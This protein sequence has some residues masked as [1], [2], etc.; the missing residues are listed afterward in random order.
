MKTFITCI[1]ISVL[2][3]PLFAQS[4][5]HDALKL[6]EY[7]KSSNFQATVAQFDPAK[8]N[9]ILDNAIPILVNY[10]PD[11]ADI[12]NEADL[13]D[14]YDGNPFI[15]PDNGFSKILLPNVFQSPS[16]AGLIKAEALP[17]ASSGISITNVA[18][19]L[20][21]F[22][23]KRTREELTIT[24]FQK[25]KDKIN[26]NPYFKE[27][28]PQTADLLGLIDNE[29]YQFNAYMESLR[30]HFVKDMKSLPINL[31]SMLRDNQILGDAEQI[32]ADDMLSIAQM[33]IDNQPPEE[34]IKFIGSESE[35]LNKDRISVLKGSV[36]RKYEDAAAGF[37]LAN[38][39]SESLRSSVQG[40]IWVKPDEL[41]ALIQDKLTLYL[42]LGL[43]W[44][45]SGGITFH[46]GSSVQSVLNEVAEKDETLNV[47]KRQ[48]SSFVD[49]A[50]EVKISLDSIQ[51]KKARNILVY[52][53]YYQFFHAT[54]SL[55][56]TGIRFKKDFFS[57]GSDS[58]E[59]DEKIISVLRHFNELNF[60]IR[61][62]HYAAGVTNLVYIFQELLDKKDFY[63]KDDLL[64]YGNF[65]AI[66]AEA[67]NSDEV[68]AAIEAVALPVGSSITKKYASFSVAVNAY[69]GVAGGQEI[70]ELK[71]KNGFFSVAAPVG[72][73][74]NTGFGKGGSLGLFTSLIDVGALAAIR[75]EDET[76]KD[77]PD[78][79]LK[80]ILAPG[81][82]VVYG[83]GGD[84]PLALGL[85]GQLGPN[86]RAIEV[87]AN[88]PAQFDSGWRWGLFLAVDIP[89]FNLYVR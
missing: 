45:E 6:R 20:A 65:I 21:K 58:L 1:I 69:T 71:G 60:N 77:L 39:L 7:L 85:G 68:A 81:A 49:Y 75:F 41:R 62:K 52:D 4:A 54:F 5:F 14:A 12:S 86:L 59:I 55:L 16:E 38:V 18:D 63:F 22:L 79:N 40:E 61:Q 27:L 47:M 26:S 56:E 23:V 44:Q 25:F 10:T 82:Y 42:Y 17:V 3:A 50:H 32:I 80:N 78:L 89:I 83:F 76:T 87:D 53:D 8:D 19:G 37:K 57:Q 28:F 67:E 24:F 48:L 64:K 9:E 36:K 74:F 30:E 33:L 43:L 13:N 15:S 72:F 2:A 35:L 29:I 84:I 70:L 88:M 46:N 11:P 34:F 66:V 73:S 51:A 31:K